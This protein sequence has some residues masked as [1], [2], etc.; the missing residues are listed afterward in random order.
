MKKS[1]LQKR[2]LSKKEMKEISGARPHCP[3]VLSCFDPNTGQEM[4]GVYGIQDGPCC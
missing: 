2:K 4:S 1:T 3:L